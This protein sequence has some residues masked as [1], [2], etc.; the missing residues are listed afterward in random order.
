MTLK[1]KS[2]DGV[3]RI[4]LPN[5][6]GPTQPVEGLTRPKKLTLPQV[7]ENSSFLIAFKLRHRLFPA[8]AL[9]LNH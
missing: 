8:L 6:G 3:E 5:V 2:V 1:F 4:A 7:R 9:K